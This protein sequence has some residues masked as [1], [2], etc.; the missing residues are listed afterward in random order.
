[1]SNNNAISVWDVEFDADILDSIA[2]LRRHLTR[3]LINSGN[4]DKSEFT[5]LLFT[6][7]LKGGLEGY[8]PGIDPF[9]WILHDPEILG[10]LYSSQEQQGANVAVV[11]S[12]SCL[13]KA[14]NH[15]Q[16]TTAI[17]HAFREAE[18]NKAVW[19]IADLDIHNLDSLT[20]YSE[21]NIRDVKLGLLNQLKLFNEL[22][23]HGVWVEVSHPDRL[24][25]IKEAFRLE[26]NLP[27]ILCFDGKNLPRLDISSLP[28]CGICLKFDSLLEAY[29]MSEA[30]VEFQNLT[31]THLIVQFEQF[32]MSEESTFD[33]INFLKQ[34]GICNFR[35]GK[36]MKR[37][38]R[39]LLYSFA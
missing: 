3:S 36:T 2:Y 11:Q 7:D 33:T 25:I 29:E 39:I 1:M 19:C 34:D 20:D 9:T 6:Q 8:V 15:E 26:G 38:E 24:G 28:S 17:K 22:G 14:E 21:E 32:A 23:A 31:H 27:S 37:D 4:D 5:P 35:P 30:L 13:E 16:A 18:N 12:G 10:E